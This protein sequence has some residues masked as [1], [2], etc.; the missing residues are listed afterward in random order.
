M[1]KAHLRVVAGGKASS[2]PA[3]VKRQVFAQ[4]RPL[5]AAVPSERIDAQQG[6][7]AKDYVH[8]TDHENKTLE[9]AKE[10]FLDKTID[11]VRGRSQ[12]YPEINVLNSAKGWYRGMIRLARSEGYSDMRK[13][14]KE[15]D[16]VNAHDKR[17][18]DTVGA[19]IEWENKLPLGG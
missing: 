18:F 13:F 11:H 8:R 19:F 4:D 14:F 2:P 5:I 16:L 10:R 9:E 7:R 15:S 1:K 17:L 3:T 6:L 12:L